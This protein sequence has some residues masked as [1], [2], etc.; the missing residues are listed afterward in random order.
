MKLSENALAIIRS[1][2][3]IDE[4]EDWQKLAIRVGS[5]AARFENGKSGEYR[6]KFA[7]IIFEGD[8]LAGG[9]ILRNMGRPRGSLFNCYVL[10][11]GDS[12]KEIG[13]WLC[14]SLIL[15]G[16]GGG[17]GCNLSFLRPRGAPIKGV[18]GESSGPVSFLE[19]SDAVAKTVESGGSRRAAALGTMIVTHPDIMEFIDAKITHGKLP[20]YNIS[21][22]VTEDF[23][24]AV[25]K[26]VDWE[27]KFAQQSFGTTKARDIWDKVVSNMVKYA[28]PGLLNWDNLRSNNSYYF[29]PIL[30]TNP[31]GEVPLSAYGVCC[32]GSLVL[33]NFITG[34]VNTNWKKLEQTIKLA[35]RFLD[36]IIDVN[37]YTLQEVDVSAHNSR[38]VGLGVM[39]LAEYLFAKKLRYGS[40][41]AI[42]EVENLMK[43]IRNVTYES[44]IELAAE[45][46]A[47]PKFDSVQFGKAHFIRSLPA[48]LRMSIK[49]KGI[50]NV[51]LMAMAPTGTISLIPEVSSGIEPIFAKAYMR[52]D[53]VSDR[54][55]IHPFYKQ[56]ITSGEET[57]D[58]FVDSFD[59]KPA[60][61]FETQAIVQKYTDGAVSKTINMPKGTTS[62]DL[63]KLTLEYIRDLKGVTVYV[64]GSRE[65]QILNTV[66][67]AEVRAYIKSGT[68]SAGA[69]EA[70]VRCSSGTCEL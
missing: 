48:A 9:R 32:L 67:D 50:R 5:E 40:K 39:G 27:F 68:D 62:E 13:Q 10:P 22:A 66:S 21:V 6:D 61:H 14:D 38:R 20:H 58:W 52:N 12:R 35:V 17:V 23:L 7:E 44:S 49:D 26:N 18:G 56:I 25:E 53:R 64:D 69:D 47:F 16:E 45:K 59:L 29:D 36:N 11:V 54:M 34:S 30:S 1:R 70:S 42:D 63:S 51:T 65:G 57:P 24:E 43:F 33:P 41:K 8:F 55:Y 28:E 31:C 2:Y 60:D 37:K 46:G 4:N 19:A 3:F 15:W